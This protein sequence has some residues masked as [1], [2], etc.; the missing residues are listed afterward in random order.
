MAIFNSY[1]SLPEGNNNNDLHFMGQAVPVLGGDLLDK[2]GDIGIGEFAAL[3]CEAQASD[4]TNGRFELFFMGFSMVFVDFGWVMEPGNDVFFDH[5]LR[6]G[7]LQLYCRSMSATF[8]KMVF[9]LFVQPIFMELDIS[10]MNRNW[11]R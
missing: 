1:V 2:L 11:R 5:D 8:G 4:Q 10:K 6:K 7:V 3:L 9:D